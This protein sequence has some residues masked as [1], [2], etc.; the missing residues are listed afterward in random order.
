M[1][2]LL[3]LEAV[4]PKV[5]VVLPYFRSALPAPACLLS[6][7]PGVPFSLLRLEA[8]NNLF[9]ALFPI[10]P[11]GGLACRAEESFNLFRVESDKGSELVQPTFDEEVSMLLASW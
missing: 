7:I 2:F 8:S 1:P 6:S 9:E 10:T 5:V 4:S 11:L 3:S